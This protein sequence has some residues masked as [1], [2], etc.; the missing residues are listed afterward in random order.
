MPFIGTIV[1]FAVVL[2]AGVLGSLV[3]LG[4]PKKIA[5]SVMSAMAISV[6]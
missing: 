6:I 3:K 4:V 2:V 5:D 1:N